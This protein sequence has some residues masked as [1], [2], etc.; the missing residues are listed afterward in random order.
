MADTQREAIRA[1][2]PERSEGESKDIYEEEGRDRLAEE[3]RERETENAL[4]AFICDASNTLPHLFIHSGCTHA[5]GAQLACIQR[6]RGKTATESQREKREERSEKSG[7]KK[8]TGL[9]TVAT[10][11]FY[12]LWPS[13]LSF[14]SSQ[15]L[16][17]YREPRGVQENTVTS[18]KGETERDSVIIGRGNGLGKRKGETEKS[19]A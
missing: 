15:F 12:L 7:G 14:R 10:C 3:E 16:S 5:D 11:T 13:R 8:Q 19:V 18:K 4:A 17:F 2:R 9:A 1:P 6:R